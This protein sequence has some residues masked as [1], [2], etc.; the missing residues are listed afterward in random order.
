[1]NPSSARALPG[2]SVV[3]PVRNEAGCI[4][5]LAAE[6]EQH[7]DVLPAWECLWVDDASTDG[8]QDLLRRLAAR[9]PRHRVLFLPEHRG[10]SAALLSGWNAA[11]HAFVGALDA[12]GQNDPADLPRL[13]RVAVEQQLDMVNGVR[14]RRRDDVV[15]RMAGRIANVL[16][17]RLTGD[18]VTDVGCS[19]RVFRRE[20]VPRLPA[21]RTVHRF[22]P[23]FVRLAGGR[24][25]E[26]EVHHRPRL[27]G[28]SKYGLLDRL[29]TGLPDVLAVRWYVRRSVPLDAREI[30]VERQEHGSFDRPREVARSPVVSRP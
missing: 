24:M 21:L 4:E 7:L 28:R 16:R 10:Q 25:G 20:L 27:E 1:M 3:V 19:T 8:S 5:T 15:R 23:T 30:E 13:L 14:A 18:S 2:L 17:N 12:D 9:G 29:W 26:I 22:L 11:R 6:I